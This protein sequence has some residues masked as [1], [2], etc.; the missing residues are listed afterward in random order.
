MLDVAG[1]GKIA[2][3]QVLYH[4]Q[5]RAIEHAVIPWCAKH[6][7]AVVAYSP[8]GHHDFPEPRSKGGELLQ[9]IADAHKATTR[10]VALSFLTRAPSVFAIP[11]ASTPEHAADNAAAGDLTLSDDEIASLGKAFPRGPKPRSLPML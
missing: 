8:F 5:E 6:N 1:E 9:T 11:K 7:V 4:L 10:Q 2:C 3:N